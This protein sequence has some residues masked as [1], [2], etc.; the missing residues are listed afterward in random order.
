MPVCTPFAPF[1]EV[2]M[3]TVGLYYDI[4]PGKGAE[5]EKKF[6]DVIEAM[7]GVAGHKQS[8]LYHRV[9]DADSYAIISEWDSQD[10]FVRFIRSDAFKQVTTWGRENVLRNAPRHKVYPMAED[11]MSGRPH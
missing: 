4:I 8:F 6:F 10:E 3:V 5:F 2:A 11:L 7:K 9:D 1:R